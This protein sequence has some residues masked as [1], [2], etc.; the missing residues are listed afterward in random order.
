MVAKTAGRQGSLQG[1]A[2]PL[3]AL[4]LL[5]GA[6]YSNS[7]R[8]AMVFDNAPILVRDARIRAATAENLDAILH[9]EYWYN[10]A[11]SGLYRPLTTLSYMF[12]SSILGE[13]A[14]PTGYHA[15]NLALHILNVWLAYAIGLMILGDWA[16]AMGLAALWGVHP[17]LTESVTNIVGRADLLAA[18]GVLAGLLCYS[19]FLAAPARR[20]WLWLVAVGVAQLI[21]VFSKESGAI[22]PGVLLVYDLAFPD[23]AIWRRRLPGYVALAPAFAAF[24]YLR[25]GV[26]TRLLVHFAENPLAGAGF[27]TS[28][29]TAVKVI[30]KLMWLFLW[31]LH[32]SAD[33]SFNA[34]PLFAW[35]P[36]WED[37]QALLALLACVA[38]L[39]VAV[40]WR[41]RN[42]ALFFLIGFFFVAIAPTSNVFLTI[43]S[44]MAVRFLYLPSIGLAGCVALVLYGRA[45]RVAP[46]VTAVLVVALAARTYARNPD[47]RDELSLW[48]A[49]VAVVP[50]SARAHNNLCNAL[51]EIPSRQRD[52]VA[53]C[54][55][56]LH[57]LP[58]YADAH[59]NLG[60]LLA[61][62]PD[63]LQSAIAQYQ[64]ALRIEPAF[65]AAHAALGNALL[66]LP[67]S[68][69]DAAREYQAALHSDPDL[70]EAHFGLGSLWSRTP[71][72]Q[73]DA[74]AE[75]QTVLDLDPDPDSNR[76]KALN[77]LG[78]VL[79]GMPGRLTEAVARFESA[80]VIDPNYANAHNNLANALLRVPGRRADAI[81]EYR[82]AIRL[83]PDFAD[84]HYNL[85]NALA[86]SAD[87][88]AE[89]IAEYRAAIRANPDMVE[90]HANLAA[91]LARLPGQLPAAIEEMQA[92][93][94][95][96]PDPALQSIL[97]RMRRRR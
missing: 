38:L 18:F 37:A 97:D 77:G 57:I 25:A 15:V 69:A 80:I 48:S 22:L 81:A 90:A 34:V 3:L 92:A 6:C 94:R 58:D 56:A 24:I 82:A 4:A 49:T 28:R 1:S 96:R 91:V 26:Q 87:G 76:A 19:R 59:F 32:L 33:Y 46:I 20:R 73:S 5:V 12:N 86:Q 78:N 29:I 83:A 71:G 16:P 53:E 39:A 89:A 85:A 62:M 40:R 93:V 75:F 70:V 2:A 43:G 61:R 66:Q 7:L 23:R 63:R 95:L 60:R 9:N 21:A 47:W 65:A 55:A 51:S 88:Q 8:G 52:A 30:G 84:A 79:S 14:N 74:I 72:R 45:R 27:L 64:T 68:A 13:G 44:I 41:R 36:A 10:A 17:V 31:P 11:P 54:N 50:N 42:R 67:G 35:R